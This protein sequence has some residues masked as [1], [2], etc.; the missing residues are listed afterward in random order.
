M[1][2]KDPRPLGSSAL[3]CEKMDLQ[4]P[5]PCSPAAP[6]KPP[7]PFATPASSLR[8]GGSG[9][10]SL[11]HNLPVTLTRYLNPLP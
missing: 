8:R 10:R 4:R 5:G 11:L 7:V 3:D 9:L 1:Q 6:S 2:Q